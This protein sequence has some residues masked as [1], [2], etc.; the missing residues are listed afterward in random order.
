MVYLV[1]ENSSFVLHSEV[2]TDKVSEKPNQLPSPVGVL[3]L[4]FVVDFIN[5]T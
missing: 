2:H 3:E 5:R 1:L 4:F